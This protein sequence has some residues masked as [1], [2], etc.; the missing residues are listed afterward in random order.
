MLI[1]PEVALEHLKTYLDEID[2]LI[3]LDYSEGKD[4]AD[5]L[6]RLIHG[7][8]ISSFE[9]ADNKL[10]Q[11]ENHHTYSI[12]NE[13]QKQ[14]M[15]LHKLKF[16]K[17]NLIG[18]REEIILKKSVPQNSRIEKILS[19]TEIKK[20][21]A[22]RRGAVAD[23]KLYGGYIELITELRNQLKEKDII[24]KELR[25]IKQEMKDIKTMIKDLKNE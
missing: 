6:D 13:A 14:N 16:I 21:E 1:D 15:Y 3:K 5:K 19:Q 4:D 18:I 8:I 20:A 12:E 22:Q 11:M 17:N 2:N 23:T 25:Q 9:D 10:N 7:F 24:T